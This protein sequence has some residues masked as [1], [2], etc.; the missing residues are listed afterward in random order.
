ML[1]GVIFSFY[2]LYFI[3]CYV[4][5]YSIYHIFLTTFRPT[6]RAQKERYNRK[7]E[8]KVFVCWVDRNIEIK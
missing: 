4:A 6:T 3:V 7:A 1:L 2:F 5:S 8:V